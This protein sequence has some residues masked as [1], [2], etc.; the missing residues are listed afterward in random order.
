MCNFFLDLHLHEHLNITKLF[1]L[2][3]YL[4]FW[5]S[6]SMPENRLVS[7]D[8]L[9]SYK[10]IKIDHRINCLVQIST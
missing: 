7:P 8:K 2:L 3:S 10:I 4:V 1:F 9:K 6:K 5:I